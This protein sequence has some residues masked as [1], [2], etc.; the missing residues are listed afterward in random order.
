LNEEPIPA[1]EADAAQPELM[2]PDSAEIEQLRNRLADAEQRARKLEIDAVRS[3]AISEHSLADD[4]VEFITAEDSAGAMAQAEKLAAVLRSG[5]GVG[6]P[7]G[8][9]PAGGRNPANGAELSAKQDE[10]D[11]FESMRRQVPALCNRVLRS[12]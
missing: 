10:Q 8:L 11:R 7:G 2:P 1:P 6:G 3:K 4:L 12:A 9:P 5:R